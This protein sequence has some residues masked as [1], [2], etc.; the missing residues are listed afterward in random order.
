[1]SGLSPVPISL[2]PDTAAV[3]LVLAWVAVL[4][5]A[6]WNR[7][8]HERFV[9]VL[10][11]ALA[12]SEVI[13]AYPVAGSQVGVAAATFIPIGGICLWDG[14]RSLQRWA[15][16]RGE[17]SL[18]RLGAFGTVA[19]LGVVVAVAYAG[20]VRPGVSN[21]IAYANEEPIGLPG[22]TQIRT[23]IGQGAAYRE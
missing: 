18:A 17:L 3:P 5:P 4:P 21:A 2:L 14:Y 1:V 23:P 20:I 12:T 9:R 13:Q 16:T 10:L 11:P 19:A 8:S 6:G 15:A 22:A 7:S